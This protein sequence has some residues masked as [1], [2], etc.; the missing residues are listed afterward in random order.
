MSALNS[1]KDVD[2]WE[3]CRRASRFESCDSTAAFTR[4][5]ASLSDANGKV[6]WS[7]TGHS[8][9]QLGCV[10]ELCGHFVASQVCYRCDLPVSQPVEFFRKLRLCKSEKEADEKADLDDEVDAVVALGYV[11]LS[12]WLEDELLL[13]LPMF[14][15]HPECETVADTEKVAVPETEISAQP[16]MAAQTRKPFA[17]LAFLKK[18]R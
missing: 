8:S 12:F 2:A 17:A 5:A 9:R 4:L 10:I 16:E 6:F 7:I 13:C 14:A 1:L 15:R 11:D 3:F 18:P